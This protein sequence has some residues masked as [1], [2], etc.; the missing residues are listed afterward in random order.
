MMEGTLAFLSAF[1]LGDA[2]LAVRAMAQRAA[3]AFVN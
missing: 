1:A 2:A 3:V